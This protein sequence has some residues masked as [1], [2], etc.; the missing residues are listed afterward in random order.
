MEETMK[1]LILAACAVLVLPSLVT[2]QTPPND[3]QFRPLL[4]WQAGHLAGWVIVPDATRTPRQL[5]LVAG[6]LTRDDRGWKEV[7]FGSVIGTD[8]VVKPVANFRSYAKSRRTDLYTEFQLRSNLALMSG[9]VTVPVTSD[10]LGW[11]VGVE[12]EQVVVFEDKAHGKPAKTTTGVGLRAS[13][14]VPKLKGTNIATTAFKNI[15]G[16]VV[17]RTYVVYKPGK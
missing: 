16:N 10:T 17:V 1:H 4:H 15:H 13:V 6:Y 2:A 12:Y 5:L 9:F 8:G 11:R 7:M 3:Y 14:K